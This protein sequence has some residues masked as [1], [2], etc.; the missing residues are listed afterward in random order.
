MNEVV[1]SIAADQRSIA[2]YCRRWRVREL[3]IF[4]S[5][6]RGELR[7]DSDI[8]VMVAFEDSTSWDLLDLSAMRTELSDMLG[9]DVD[10]IEQG[11]ISD[12]Q[13]RANIERDRRVLY[14]A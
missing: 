10:L 1:P 3:A 13:R 7:A 4:G 8:D 9:R 14:A 11:T 5:A 6:S 12:P 2:E